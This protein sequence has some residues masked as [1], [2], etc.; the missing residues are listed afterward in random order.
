MPRKNIYEKVLALYSEGLDKGREFLYSNMELLMRKNPLIRHK[1]YTYTKDDILSEAFL[2]AD[3]IILRKNT[4][5]EKKISRLWYLFNRGW[6]ILY[7][8]I[9]QYN[10]E[11]Y[12]IDDISD[13]EWW[14]YYMDDEMLEYVLL[15]N[16]VITPLESQVLKYLQ[17]WRWKYEIAR[18]MKT[19]YHNLKNIVDTMTLKIEKFY[20]ENDINADN[21]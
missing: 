8:K 17:E 2:S 6:G 12:C 5:D 18:L 11:T 3:D 7:N 19:S 16:K 10:S 1:N 14:S 20:K 21:S 13:N 9:N 4:S 15:S